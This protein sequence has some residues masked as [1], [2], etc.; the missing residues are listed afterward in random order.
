V[1]ALLQREATR[2]ALDVELVKA[3]V[4]AES[5]FNARAVSPAGA[6]GLIADPFLPNMIKNNTFE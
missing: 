6:L 5:G 3:V 1:S 2:H 4:A